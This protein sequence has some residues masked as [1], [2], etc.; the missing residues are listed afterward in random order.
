MRN[1]FGLSY[2]FYYWQWTVEG[3]LNWQISLFGCFV[4]EKYP[5]DHFRG[6]MRFLFSY[7]LTTVIWMCCGMKHRMRRVGRCWVNEGKICKTI[8]KMNV[9]RDSLDFLLDFHREVPFPVQSDSSSA[10]LSAPFSF[11]HQLSGS[12]E[13]VNDVIDFPISIFWLPWSRSSG[14]F[15][16]ELSS[17]FVGEEN[18]CKD[19]NNVFVNTD[20]R[21]KGSY[22]LIK[23]TIFF[24]KLMNNKK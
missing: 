14:V 9:K 7:S 16:H 13:K 15:E 10:V 23:G 4:S 20:E 19:K 18:C 6:W 12:R 5:R 17:F 24:S 22:S 3:A 8:Q 21:L 1:V 2:L 11:Y